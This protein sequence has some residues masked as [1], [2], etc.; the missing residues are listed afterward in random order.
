M[1][2]Q[3]QLINIIIILVIIIKWLPEFRRKMLYPL[4]SRNAHK[5]LSDF[6][7]TQ[8]KGPES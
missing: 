7:K 3:L 2:T 4:Q 1:T 6:M 5:H 8:A